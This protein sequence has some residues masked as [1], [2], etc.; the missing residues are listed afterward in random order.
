VTFLTL[1]SAREKARDY[2]VTLKR[3][4]IDPCVLLVPVAGTVLTIEMPVFQKLYC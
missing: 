4:G 1:S 2:E 3:E